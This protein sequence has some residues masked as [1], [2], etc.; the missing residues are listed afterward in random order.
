M[1]TVNNNMKSVLL[2]LS[3]VF[4]GFTFVLTMTNGF[5]CVTTTRSRYGGIHH[6]HHRLVDDVRPS[7]TT[8]TMYMSDAFAQESADGTIYKY[9]QQFTY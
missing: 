7:T 9:C 5:T 4:I 3:Y 8:T 6:H 2:L 1:L